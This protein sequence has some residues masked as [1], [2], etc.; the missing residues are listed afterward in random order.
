MHVTV[1]TLFPDIFPGPLG[2]SL[3]GKA[4][5]DSVFTLRIVDLKQFSQKSGRVDGPPCGGGCGMLLSAKVLEA[6][7][8]SLSP[9]E[10]SFT[11]HFIYFSPRGTLFSQKTAHL[12]SQQHDIVVLCGRYEG[13]DARILEE[14]AFAEISMG[15]YV[16]MGGEIAAMAFIE[17][18]V[19]LIPGVVGAPNSLIED[20]F[21]AAYASLLEYPQYTHP[22][23]WKRRSVPSVLLS[24]DHEAVRQWRLTQA[25]TT[26]RMRRPDLWS[27]YVAKELS[28]LQKDN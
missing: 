10:P 4:L 18:N 20:S 15:D 2:V 12:F 19:R 6:A 5:E 22:V 1:L 23:H 26:T 11:R 24:G 7:I 3:L 28:V 17:A 9:P 14:Y 25:R 16:L 21:V 13:I 8:A 27:K